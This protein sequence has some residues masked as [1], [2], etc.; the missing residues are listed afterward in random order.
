MF[1][2]FQEVSKFMSTILSNLI[3]SFFLSLSHFRSFLR[4]VSI[5]E[6]Q[7]KFE[8]QKTEKMMTL[9]LIDRN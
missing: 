3:Y 7:K 1:T 5:F 9:K 2:Q 8:T 4:P 6:K